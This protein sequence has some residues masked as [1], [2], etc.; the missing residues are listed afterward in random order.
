MV[1][2]GKTIT[3]LGRL[4]MGESKHAPTKLVRLEGNHSMSL[5]SNAYEPLSRRLEQ[6]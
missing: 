2:R 3:A 4:G 1:C 5:V 6:K